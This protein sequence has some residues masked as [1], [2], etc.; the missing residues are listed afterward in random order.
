MAKMT[1]YVAC[2]LPQ[3]FKKSR[4]KWL[5]SLWWNKVFALLFSGVFENHQDTGGTGSRASD[6]T[7]GRGVAPGTRSKSMGSNCTWLQVAGR[8]W[9][10]ELDEA[11]L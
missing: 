10:A 4:K 3:F 2:I 9:L 8:N 11:P 1:S 7:A 6:T 5:L